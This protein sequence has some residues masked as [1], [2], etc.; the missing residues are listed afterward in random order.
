VREKE[1]TTVAILGTD[2]AVGWAI[3]LL[4]RGEGYE[5]RMVEASRAGLPEDLI[6]GVDLLLIPRTLPTGAVTRAFPH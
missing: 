3:L 6:E 2:I 4:L 5:I 1:K